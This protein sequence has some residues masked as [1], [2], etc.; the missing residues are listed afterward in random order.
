MAAVVGTGFAWS[1]FALQCPATWAKPFSQTFTYDLTYTNQYPSYLPYIACAPPYDAGVAINGQIIATESGY[2]LCV[3]PKAQVTGKCAVHKEVKDACA[4]D[5]YSYDWAG[6]VSC[7]YVINGKQYSCGDV[8]QS[9]SY[10]GTNNEE[11]GPTCQT[12]NA[13]IG[14]TGPPAGVTGPPPQTTGPLIIQP[15]LDVSGT[16]TVTLTFY[17]EFSECDTYPYSSPPPLTK[18]FNYNCTTSGNCTIE[19]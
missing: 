10:C 3:Y 4:L 1:S 6:S 15:L 17:D 9:Y 13:H 5:H 11:Y 16:Y 14:P 12:L 8:T 2:F 19:E 7:E 18:T